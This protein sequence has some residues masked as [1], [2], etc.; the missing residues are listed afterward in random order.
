MAAFLLI[1][2]EDIIEEVKEVLN[3]PR[4]RDKIPTSYP[5]KPLGG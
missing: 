3:R 5:S 2:S 4:I 1:L